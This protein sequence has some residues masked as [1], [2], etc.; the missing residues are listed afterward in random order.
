MFTPAAEPTSSLTYWLPLLTA[1]LGFA[2]GMCTEWL[3]DHRTYKRDKEARESSRRDVK[4]D[5]QNEFQRQ[6]LLDLQDATMTLMQATSAILRSERELDPERNTLSDWKL[7]ELDE[8][9]MQANALTAK[10]GVRVDD[11]EVRR[12]LKKLKD[13]LLETTLY[14]SRQ[15]RENAMHKSTFIF[16]ELNER[17][18]EIV[19]A[20]NRA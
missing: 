2:S 8:R 17:I 18:G 15:G 4:V 16:V 3:R 1:F 20:I 10:L 6:T 19:R 11:E 9:E 12:L 7:T 5:R 14:S 13:Q